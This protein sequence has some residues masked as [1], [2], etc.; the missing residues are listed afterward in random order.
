MSDKEYEADLIT[1][2][3]DENKEHTFEIIDSIEQDDNVYY[4]LIPVYDDTEQQLESAD[5]Y[6]IFQTVEENGEELLVEVEDEALLDKLAEIF[7]SR[8]E[9]LFDEE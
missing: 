2:V 8:F 7:E 4:A 5:E 3:D 6:Y 1:L 9:E